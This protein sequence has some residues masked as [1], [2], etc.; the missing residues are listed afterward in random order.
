MVRRHLLPPGKFETFQVIPDNN[1]QQEN[2]DYKPRLYILGL[3]NIGL[4]KAVQ[5]TTNMC[6]YV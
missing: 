2:S 3:F 6:K 4:C 1:N 5:V